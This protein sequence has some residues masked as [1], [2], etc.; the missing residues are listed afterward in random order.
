MSINTYD[1][2]LASDSPNSAS[3]TH[4]KTSIILFGEGSQ[5][6][7]KKERDFKRSHFSFSLFYPHSFV[8]DFWLLKQFGAE[9]NKVQPEEKGSTRK[10]A[11][12][13]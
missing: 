13:T 5:A 2:H 7:W 6:K 3:C 12:S 9:A 4:H 8:V 1:V 11:A 10:L